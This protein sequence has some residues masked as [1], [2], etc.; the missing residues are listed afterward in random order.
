[1]QSNIIN[2]YKKEWLLKHSK[3]FCMLPWLHLY[4]DPV[5]QVTPCCVAKTPVGSSLQTNL[6]N[7]VNSDGMKQLR[8]NM[9]N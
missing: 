6:E 5:G 7:L 1:M 8:V 9:L 3:S 4:S 2:L